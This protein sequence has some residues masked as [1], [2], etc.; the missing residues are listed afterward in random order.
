M[1]C[2]KINHNYHERKRNSFSQGYYSGAQ[3][4]PVSGFWFWFMLIT[5]LTLLMKYSTKHAVKSLDRGEQGG[6][7]KAHALGVNSET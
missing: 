1:N 4:F 3:I 7:K 5:S 2:N 6:K